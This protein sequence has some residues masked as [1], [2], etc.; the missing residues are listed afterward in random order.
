MLFSFLLG[1]VVGSN[2]VMMRIWWKNKSKLLRVQKSILIKIKLNYS[3]KK[4][5][6]IEFMKISIK[7]LSLTI[8]NRDKNVCIIIKI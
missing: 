1:V 6:D 4:I 2:K 7:L 8:V 5:N 3:L